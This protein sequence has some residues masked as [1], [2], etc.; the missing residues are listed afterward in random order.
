M[1][2]VRR[3]S[4]SMSNPPPTTS[5]YVSKYKAPVYNVYLAS[6]LLPISTETKFPY[7]NYWSRRRDNNQF[8]ISVT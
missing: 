3:L 6:L 5:E 7:K 8:D 1:V 2:G 4:P